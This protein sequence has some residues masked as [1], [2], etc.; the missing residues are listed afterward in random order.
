MES[1]V[2]HAVGTTLAGLGVD[3]VFGLAGSGNFVVTN[4][5]VAGGARFVSARHEG[6]AVAM[7]DGWA[8]TTGRVGV[9]SV[10]QGPGLTNTLTALAE[11]AKAHTPLV[12]LAGDTPPAAL[13]SNVRID[14][15]DLVRAV[16]AAPELLYSAATAAGDAARALRRARLERRPVVLMMPIDLA[17][18]AAPRPAGAIGAAALPAHPAPAPAAITQAADLLAAAERPA[19]IAGRGAV[20]ADARDVVEALADRTGALL[21]T[22][23]MANGLFAG[24]P[25]ALGISGGF[26]S[27]LAARLL[28]DSDVILSLGA[29]LNHWT[30]RHGALL[31]ARPQLISVD[32]EAGAIG[33]HQPAAVGIVA[34]ARAA[35]RALLAELE[36]RDHRATGRRT[37]QIADAIATRRWRDEPYDDDPPPD[38]IDP[39]TL[40]IALDDLLPRDR[41]VAVDSGAF[42]GWPAM[43]LDV[44]DPRAWLFC[45]AFQSVGLGFGAALGAAVARPDRITVAALGDG[46]M[47]LALPE[48]DTAAR[49][50]LPVLV[51]VWNDAAYGAEVHH[52]GPMGQDVAIA[53]FPDADLA[54]IAR[55]AGVA[56]HTVRRRADLA[57]VAAWAADPDG[58]LLLDAKVDPGVAGDWLEEAFRGG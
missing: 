29:G 30:T 44:A 21:A 50:G 57:P 23:A 58:P 38:T 11:A 52:F 32:V 26:A 8:R 42:T 19:I 36:A 55:G 53:R 22:S 16:G 4:A 54:A 3:T 9:A 41:A 14:Q 31:A 47:F 43:Y 28:A 5:L 39:R 46:G 15:H 2:A 37:A 6:G 51:V 33:A 7:A 48:L 13:R 25:Y 49:L 35:A 45:N 34:D 20:L 40:A 27:P 17:A 12:V 10:H 24:L 56:A 18:A 1:T